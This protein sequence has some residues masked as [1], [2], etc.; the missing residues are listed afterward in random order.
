MDLSSLLTE[1]VPNTRRP[2]NPVPHRTPYQ[3]AVG[4]LA[5]PS[6]SP[7]TEPKSV[8]FALCSPPYAPYVHQPNP[9]TVKYKIHPHDT[10]E[11]ITSS[12]QNF[13]GLFSHDKGVK[14]LF[15]VSFEDGRGNN[16]IL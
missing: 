8:V 2:S 13:F 10:T 16:L 12:V 14:T 9:P 15:R 4:M 7:S 11:S 1:D 6:H 3:G 5:T